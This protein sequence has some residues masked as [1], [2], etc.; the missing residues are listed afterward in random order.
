[1]RPAL[2]CV[3][4]RWRN[5]AFSEPRLWR[6]I[7]V[8]PTYKD[9]SQQQFIEPIAWLLG[10]G[11]G[12]VVGELVIDD[13]R[14]WQ[15]AKAL[16]PLVGPQ[17]Q[18]LSL[19]AAA[20]L[21]DDV[22]ASLADRFPHLELLSLH[23]VALP[24]PTLLAS[25]PRLA[26]LRIDSEGS[27]PGGLMPVV[28][29]LTRLT[30]LRLACFSEPLSPVG[31]LTALRHLASLELS[32]GGD[33]AASPLVVAPPAGFPNM[34]SL[35]LVFSE[36]V[37]LTE[38]STMEVAGAT[39]T[40]CSYN[41]HLSVPRNLAS[42][43]PGECTQLAALQ[44]LDIAG[45][46]PIG[47]FAEGLVQQTPHLT[48]LGLS[49][50]GLTALPPAA[51]GLRHLKMLDCSKTSLGDLPP[52]PYLSGLTFFNL[53]DTG[54][55]RLP[56]VLANASCLVT[57]GLARCHSLTVSCVATR[58]VL[59]GLTSLQS[60]DLRQ[61]VV[62]CGVFCLLRRGASDRLRVQQMDDE[63]EWSEGE[64]GGWD[65]GSSTSDS[66]GDGAPRYDWGGCAYASRWYE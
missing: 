3:S 60:V 59:L 9:E 27:L 56:P 7:I 52:G 30:G 44:E 16:L 33:R 29:R 41:L 66:S 11:V 42:M 14:G 17:L 39:F 32:D 21:P 19:A 55:T 22:A 45:G 54:L 61:T 49:S 46:A 48:S 37:D 28:E 31:G 24:A 12:S 5:V 13:R 63:G 1:M 20:E 43:V 18:S 25:F 53:S 4:R 40:Y 62:E 6:I 23:D 58:R 10:R 51:V 26:D 8:A 34:Q 2:S 35:E 50:C 36:E 15:L 38:G 64:G 57:L 47:Q 65:G